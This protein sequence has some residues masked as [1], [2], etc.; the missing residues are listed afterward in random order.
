MNKKLLL[1]S[2]MLPFLMGAQTSLADYSSHE[3]TQAFIEEMVLEEGFDR[4]ELRELFQ[5]VEKKQSIIDAISRPAER[6]LTWAEYRKI[7]LK[8]GRIDDGAKFW[9]ENQTALEAAEETYGVPAEIIV[10]IIGVETLYG[11]ITGSYRVMDALSTLAFD[12]PKRAPFFRSELKHFLILS[13]EQGKPPLELKGSYA[14]AMGLGQFMPSSYRAYAADY[15][16][17]GFIDIWAN[18]SDAI[19]SVANYLEDHGWKREQPITSK[20]TASRQYSDAAIS[21]KLKPALSLQEIENAGISPLMDG[22][23]KNQR[24][25]AMRLQGNRGEEFWIGLHNFYVITRYNHSKLYAMAVFQLAEEIRKTYADDKVA[26]I[27]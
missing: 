21:K 16:K 4:S 15:D 5:Q 25:T 22:L 23:D 1:T 9:R 7:F 19:W 26:G 14:G 2:L 10:A 13:R 11:R 24:V 8:R 12:Y 3:L 18:R 17:D 27:H 6:T 20:A